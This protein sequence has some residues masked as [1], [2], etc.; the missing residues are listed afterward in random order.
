VTKDTLVVSLSESGAVA[1]AN[2]Q[3]V[4]TGASGV[5]TEVDVQTGE[6]V[7]AG[8]VIARVALDTTSQQKQAAALSSYLSAK[9]SLTNAQ[10]QLNTLQATLFQANQAF[11]K[12]RGVVNPSIDQQNDP[13][14]IE[15]NATW[16]A[17][18]ANYKNQQNVIAA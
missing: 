15:E 2:R 17:A 8:Q 14:Y 7:T 5:V 13:V 16:L 1:V 11:I 18:E 9:N 3:P 6:A 12:D 10:T 4:T